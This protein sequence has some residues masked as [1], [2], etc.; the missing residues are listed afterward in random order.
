MNLQRLVFSLVVAA[1]CANG[2]F[3]TAVVLGTVR[4]ASQA[5]M[6]HAVVSL[7]NV[8][9]GIVAK[10]ETDENGNYLFPNVKLGRYRVMAEKPGFSRTIAEDFEVNVNA[11]Q[12]VD[13][14][15]SVSQV[16]ESVE[17]RAV[18]SVL[19]SESTER[20][21]VINQRANVELPQNGRN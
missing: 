10:T 11:R 8:G 9:T 6:S 17:V 12:R 14:Q 13:L 2:Q 19:E 5:P 4:D 20:G 18:V 7:S 3:E 1:C 21:Q 16:S 15:L